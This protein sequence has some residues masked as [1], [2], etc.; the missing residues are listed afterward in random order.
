MW[1]K[2]QICDQKWCFP[3]SA[4]YK[5]VTNLTQK[6]HIHSSEKG[7]NNAFSSLKLCLDDFFFTRMSQPFV[8]WLIILWTLCYKMIKPLQTIV[9]NWA[10]AFAFA[11]LQCWDNGPY[12]LIMTKISRQIWP[13]KS[14]IKSS[15]E[16]KN[17]K[18][19]IDALGNKSHICQDITITVNCLT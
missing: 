18:L 8:S 11:P 15:L 1:P 12:N 16:L 14:K 13:I 17:N 19:L 4:L 3:Y 5:L 2:L 10:F 7:M 9:E 6:L